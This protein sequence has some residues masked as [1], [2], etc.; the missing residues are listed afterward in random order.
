[1]P[2][3][4]LL[5][6]LAALL[7]MAMILAACGEETPDTAEEEDDG[8]LALDLDDAEEE[9]EVV[10]EEDEVVEEDVDVVATANQ[11]AQ[12]LPDGWAYSNDIDE[13]KDAIS[14]DGVVLI[15]VREADEFD[16]GHIPGAVNIPIRELGENLDAIPTDQPVWIYC[17]SGWRAGLAN[18]S[19][20][21]MGYDN[22]SAYTPGSAGWD[23][24]GEELVNEDN[25][26]ESFGDPGLAPE[27]VEAVNGFLTTI[28]EGFYVAGD[29][30][31]IK[32]AMDAGS[33]LVD[34]RQPEEYEEGRIEGAIS[35]P[36]RSV[37][38]QSDDIPTD[39]NVIITCLSGYRASLALPIL[40]VAGFDNLSGFPGSFNAWVEAGEAVEA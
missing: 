36:L 28:P 25:E 31:A 13:F 27:M 32:D 19:L 21:L 39:Q 23:A 29:V 17:L 2:A 10:E 37:I 15:D 22:I 33:V 8:E 6:L 1:M 5:T 34:V 14:V 7:A 35:V 40:A 12:T 30:D 11:V 18:S 9:E 26:M 20:R 38:E 16:E 4:R 24:A 3:S